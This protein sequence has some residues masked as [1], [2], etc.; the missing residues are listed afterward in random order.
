MSSGFTALKELFPQLEQ[1]LINAGAVPGDVIGNVRWFQHGYYKAKFRSGLGGIVLSRPLLEGTIRNAVR[2]LPNI[3]FVDNSHIAG[4]VSD[5]QRRTI[6]G[7]RIQRGDSES[8]MDAALV[9]DASGRSSRS[10]QWLQDLGY[11]PPATQTVEVGLGYTTRTFKRRARDLD[12]DIGAVIGPRP[13]GM[14][15]VGFMLAMEGSRWMVTLGG[16]LGEH[17]PTDPRGFITFARSL[18]APDIYDVI[19]DAVPL[20][21]AVTYAFPANL[22][23][24]Y[25]KLTR[26]PAGYLV[27]G[28]AVCSFNPFYGQGMSV[29]ALEG[30]ALDRIL[31]KRPAP[32]RLWRPFVRATGRIVETPWTIA[33]GSDFAF[34]AVKGTKPR[35]TDFIN[36]YLDRVHRVASTDRVLCRTFF[37][38][39][40]LLE[41]STTL[42]SPR[43]VARVVR[44]CV[45]AAS[46]TAP[47]ERRDSSG[48]TAALLPKRS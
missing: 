42:F 34:P 20:T 14:K 6:V 22:R 24:R 47:Q 4:L 16:W 9:I 2:K 43:V 29:A 10:P 35:G 31:A 37:D 48:T 8:V 13:P 38:V 21:E 40:N 7:V 39:A 11:E 25:E 45:L 28:D 41:P 30:L 17:A 15:R 32:D 19:K 44:G 33:A 12:G 23:R 3:T 26:F 5:R 36:W 1:D 46:E 27:M 18:A